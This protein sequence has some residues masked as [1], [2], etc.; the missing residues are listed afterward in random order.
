MGL[1]NNYFNID[2]S[3]IKLC[4]ENHCVIGTIYN[5]Y[6]INKCLELML[7]YEKING[8]YDFIIKIRPDLYINDIE[9][10]EIINLVKLK[11][12][13][14]F[15]SKN[16]SNNFQKSD[17]FFLGNRSIFIDFIK[18]IIIYRNKIW[19]NHYEQS[20]PLNLV[21]IGERLFNLVII[22]YNFDYF[23]LNDKETKII[24]N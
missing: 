18:K 22:E 19:K 16:T 14:I 8:K 2:K 12:N 4:G 21:P 1:Y 3:I 24:R 15:V 7:E 13:K 5:I 10:E 23:I 9:F 17:K 6:H 11:K 20:T